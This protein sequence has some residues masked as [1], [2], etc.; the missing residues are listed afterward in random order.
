MKKTLVLALSCAALLAEE[1]PR[2]S[3]RPSNSMSSP[4]FEQAPPFSTTPADCS[5]RTPP[6][7]KIWKWI[8]KKILP[9][10]QRRSSRSPQSIKPEG[11][12]IDLG[13]VFGGSP[14][15]YSILFGLSISSLAIWGYLLLKLRNSELV[16]AVACREVRERLL[17]KNYGE[18]L[19]AVRKHPSIL[20]QMVSTGIQSRN[21]PL[22]PA[23]YHESGRVPR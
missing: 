18:A 21:H 9:P 8:P 22:P 2:F 15:I 14:T 6:S 12:V 20:F 19:I 7:S 4:P 11:I 3:T 5:S 1:V 13:Q 17:S 10:L 23:R 16:P